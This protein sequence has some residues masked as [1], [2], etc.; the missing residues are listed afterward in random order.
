MATNV[1]EWLDATAAAYPDK[2]AIHDE[3]GELTFSQYRNKALA[4][5]RAIIGLGLGGSQP[6]AIYLKKSAKVLVSF[7]AAAYS[8]DFYS[9][10][11]VEMPEARVRKILE[12]L[13]PRIVVTDRAGREAFQAFD[14]DG[15]YILY[16]EVTEKADDWE[17]VKKVRQQTI[18]TDLLYVLFTSGSTGVPKGVCINHGE[19]INFVTW[20]DDIFRIT[21]KDNFGNQ[22]PFYFDASVQDIYSMMK[23]GSSL[24]IIPK[25]LFVQP[26]RLLQYL[27]EHEITTIF[28]VPSALMVVSRLR[29]FRNVDVSGVLKRVLF[30]GEVMPNKQLNIWRK[31]LPD[32]LFANLYGPTETDVCTCYIVDREF[33]DDDP[34]PIGFPIH[35]TEILVLDEEDHPVTE[36]GRLGELCARGACLSSGYYNNPERTRMAFVQNPCITSHEDKIYRTG[37]LVRYNEYGELVYAGRKDF[38]VKHLGHRIELGEIENAVSALPGIG[39]CCCLYDTEKSKIVLII[40]GNYTK[41]A[42]NEKLKGAVPDYMIP[43]KLICM[44]HMPLSA[45]GKVDRV[46]LRELL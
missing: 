1:T 36:P 20:F 4:L 27:K 38:Q 23:M 39:A 14:Y 43:G 32:A 40:E 25:T 18:S 6:V 15:N 35:D 2:V 26:V 10:I 31:N 29:A 5:S 42:M 41:E 45:N 33:A 9:P 37:D 8:R 46:K 7:A 28:W 21:E 12:I 13:K 30:A 16:E 44:E 17:I 3:E 19:V 34:L 24:Y 11:D 22:T